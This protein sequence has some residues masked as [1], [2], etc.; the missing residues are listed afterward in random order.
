LLLR[1]SDQQEKNA[2]MMWITKQIGIHDNTIT[3]Q[4]PA[5]L[6]FLPDLH[7]VYLFNNRFSG[8]V[9]A[10]IGGCLVVPW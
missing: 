5:T 9:P 3:G 7:I 10:S 4:I 8:A 6:G 2:W 1:G